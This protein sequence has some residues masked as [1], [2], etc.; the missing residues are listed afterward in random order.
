MKSYRFTAEALTPIHI[1][2]GL[3]I[4]PTEFNL[5][6]D[7]LMRFSPSLIIDNLHHDERSRFLAILDR[8]DIKEIQN[9]LRS[10]FDESR[11]GLGK[12]EVS[13]QF[14]Q[15]F[16]ARISNPGSQFR[17][18]MMPRNNHSGRVYIPGSSLKGAIRTAVI[19]HFTNQVPESRHKVHDAVRAEKRNKARVLEEAALNRRHNETH[20][21]LFRFIHVDDIILPDDA[22]RIDRVLNYKVSGTESAIPMW[23]ERLKS[24]ADMQNPPKFTV[25]LR[26]NEQAM[27]N[28][29]VRNEVGRTLD[30]KTL[31]H[32]CNH[33]YWQRMVSEGDCFDQRQT[34]GDGW[35][36]IKKLFP[37]GKTED[38]KI[39]TIEPSTPF[40]NSPEYQRKRILLRVGRFCHFE[41]LSVDHLREG[42]NIQAR[43][44]IKGMGSSR[45]RCLLENGS[46]LVPFGWMV[47]MTDL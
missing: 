46:R 15:E 1:G 7:R 42:W 19:N 9:F 2:C 13:E 43:R 10:H 39:V 37:K 36:F 11:H 47:L 8:A 3:E 32:A 25:I 44:P 28:E 17:V 26:I 6:G 5:K 27:K 38:G 33:F 21:D 29:M 23:I 40:W 22:T 35:S 45:T 31:M 20:K 18:E 12:I 16:R 24:R 34:N 4:D 41:S 14:S 30:L